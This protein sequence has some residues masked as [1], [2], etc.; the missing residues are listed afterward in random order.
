MADADERS[1]DEEDSNVEGDSDDDGDSNEDDEDEDEEEE[2]DGDGDGD[3][4]GGEGADRDEAAG[5]NPE[6]AGQGAQGGSGYRLICEDMD[7][8]PAVRV[9][10]YGGPWRTRAAGADSGWSALATEEGEEDGGDAMRYRELGDIA[11]WSVTSAK[12]GNGVELLRDGNIETYWQSDGSQP[13]LMSVQF[14]RKV[15]LAELALYTDFRKDESYTPSKISVRAGNSYQDLKEVKVVE[16]NEPQG[17]V[18]VSLLTSSQP[19]QGPRA[20]AAAAADE[21][22]AASYP[23]PLR[24]HM[25]QIAVIANHQNGR[26][27]HVRQVKIYGPR[28][29]VPPPPR[30]GRSDPAHRS[31]RAGVGSLTRVPVATTLPARSATQGLCH[32]DGLPAPVH[33]RGVLRALDHTVVRHGAHR[34]VR[35]GHADAHRRTGEATRL[36]RTRGDLGGVPAVTTR[37]AGSLC[38]SLTL[39]THR[40]P[41]LPLT[42]KC[43]H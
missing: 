6:A 37:P 8:H 23:A 20:G 41:P 16:L 24:C 4:D 15:R 13:H 7:G 25:L 12:P 40:G 10:R 21:P 2:E 34:V 36:S 31:P 1:E 43:K 42:Y 3:G 27:T 29:C 28:Q 33:L 22:G 32:L 39:V 19:A 5:A 17:W 14:Q 11:V 35:Q 18:I 38:V 9:N 30:R 26:D